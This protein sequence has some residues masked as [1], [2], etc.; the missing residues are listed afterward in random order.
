MDPNTGKIRAMPLEFEGNRGM[1]SFSVGEVIQTKGCYF[2]ITGVKPDPN[3]T[4]V[5][6]GVPKKLGKER[7][8][9]QDF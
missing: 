3:N 1:R 7:F 5:M 6:R 8:K 2:E 4:I 9:K